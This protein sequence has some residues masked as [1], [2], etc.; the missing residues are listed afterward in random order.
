MRSPASQRRTRSSAPA[1]ALSREHK[2]ACPLLTGVSSSATN[3]RGPKASLS[4]MWRRIEHGRSLRIICPPA[5]K[6]RGQCAPSLD[7]TPPSSNHSQRPPLADTARPNYWD[8]LGLDSDK[9][10]ELQSEIDLTHPQGDASKLE[11]T[12][13]GGRDNN[14]KTITNYFPSARR[15]VDIC[16]ALTSQP[17]ATPISISSILATSATDALAS[18]GHYRYRRSTTDG[19]CCID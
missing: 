1:S 8:T 5:P 2:S 3:H 12:E 14:L 18:L 13:G 19:K 16:S 6:P 11:A 10:A 9:D 4:H 7:R 17:E 15:L